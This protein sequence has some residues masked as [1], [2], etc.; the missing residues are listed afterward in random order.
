MDAGMAKRDL[1]ID[2]YIESAA[3]FARPILKHL[4]AIVHGACPQVAEALKWGHPHFMYRGMLCGMSAFKQH[5]AFGF[6]KGTLLLAGQPL[7][8]DA[9]GQFG[10]LSSIA[11]LPARAT[12]RSLIKAAMALND[13]GVKSPTRGRR[14]PRPPARTPADLRRVLAKNAAA[15][16]TYAGL[17]LSGR[18]EYVEWLEEAKRPETRARRLAMTL[19]WLAAGKGR[20]WKYERPAPR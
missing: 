1:R 14:K 5:C 2:A 11:D 19:E 4:R 8:K 3:P 18:R 13:A 6:W 20:N 15:R 12:I 17:S 10:R 9:M 7:N 16:A